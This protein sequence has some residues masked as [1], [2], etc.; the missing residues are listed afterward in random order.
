MAKND[1]I[2]VRIFEQEVG[3]I[4]LDLDRGRTSFQF[5]PDFLSKGKYVGIFPPTRIIRSVSQVQV[6]DQYNTET[7]K[8]LPPPF[9]D[10]LPDVF[11]NMIFKAWLESS[12]RDHITV[13][14][15]LAYVSNR[16]MGAFEYYPSQKLKTQ[17]D[18]NLDDIV[19][20]LKQVMDTKK[21]IRSTQLNTEGL[22][23]IFKVGTSAGGARP[24]ILISKNKKTGQII[25]GDLAYKEDYDHLLVKLAVKD[26]YPREVIEYCYYLSATQAGITMMDSNLIDGKHFATKRYDRIDGEKKHVLT[27]S[28]ITGWDFKSPENSSYENLFKLCSFLKVPHGQS[29][30]LFRRMIFNLVFA[31]TDDHLKN[32]SFSYDREEQRW[33]LS[34]A[35]DITYALNPLTDYKYT[36]RAL[37]VNSKRNAI[38]VDDV[39]QIAQDYTIKNPKGIIKEVQAAI[40]TLQ[41]NLKEHDVSD[42]VVRSMMKN[43]KPLL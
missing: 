20:V 31:N 32:H 12:G 24:K 30:E 10:S 34:P 38:T 40:P 2:N 27:T 43:I 25:S 11:G 9:A 4:G 22:F 33:F 18:I 19:E 8:S 3:K 7:F 15:Q 17:A 16:G 39:I 42:R 26:L 5:H 6:F 41:R 28:G 37:S 23:N 21:S 1:V 36:S 13:I 35:Y 29:D 14:E